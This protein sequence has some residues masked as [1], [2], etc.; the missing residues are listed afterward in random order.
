MHRS[1]GDWLWHTCLERA[2]Q[3]LLLL[4]TW[5]TDDIFDFG[6]LSHNVRIDLDG[7]FS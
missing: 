3:R 7:L 2:K 4:A 1:R 6:P 5:R